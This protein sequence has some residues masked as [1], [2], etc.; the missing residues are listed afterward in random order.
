M[1]T[2]AESGTGQ[3]PSPAQAPAFDDAPITAAATGSQADNIAQQCDQELTAWRARDAA[4]GEMDYLL[5]IQQLVAWGLAPAGV[6]LPGTMAAGN[7]GWDPISL[8]STLPELP[9]LPMSAV[10]LGAL[11]SGGACS[12]LASR[13]RRVSHAWGAAAGAAVAGVVLLLAAR[14]LPLYIAANAVITRGGQTL[15]DVVV[16]VH[17]TSTGA[18]FNRVRKSSPPTGLEGGLVAEVEADLAHEH[19][20]LI[21]FG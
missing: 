13:A 19:S 4:A 14:S 17:T 5:S 8:V 3:D 2:K 18:S 11:A 20:G 6:L 15:E 10:M 12:F 16:K 9:M 7:N 1:T 21:E